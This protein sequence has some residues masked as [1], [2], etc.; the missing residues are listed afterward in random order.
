M[1]P[2]LVAVYS[3]RTRPALKLAPVDTVGAR[4]VFGKIS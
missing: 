4:K 2:A 3:E 1:D